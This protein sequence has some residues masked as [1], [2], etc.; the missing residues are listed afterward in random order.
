MKVNRRRF[1]LGL[2]AAAAGEA[3]FA[4]AAGVPT[5][6][7]APDPLATRVPFDGPHQAGVLAEP[8]D[9]VVLASLDAIASGRPSSAR[10]SPL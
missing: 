10:R 7:A 4:T 9:A 2:G 6:A 8:R 3:V 1:L 5:A